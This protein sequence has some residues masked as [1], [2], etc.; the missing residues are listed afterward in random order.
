MK[1]GSFKHENIVKEYIKRLENKQKAIIERFKHYMKEKNIQNI[2]NRNILK[3]IEKLLANKDLAKDQSAK[4]RSVIYSYDIK[5]N[6]YYR[7]V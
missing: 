1:V 7:G 2:S 5:D 4:L 6:D 3:G